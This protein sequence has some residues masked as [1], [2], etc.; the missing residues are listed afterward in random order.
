L[1]E[2]TDTLKLLEAI[3]EVQRIIPWRISRQQKWTGNKHVTLSYA[4]DSWC[5]ITM[6]KWWTAQ[7][8]FIVCKKEDTSCLIEKMYT[9]DIIKKQ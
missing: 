6:K 5:K 3:K 8:V 9:L 2:F 4:T 1:K 7:E